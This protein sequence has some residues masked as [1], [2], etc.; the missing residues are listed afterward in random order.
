MSIVILSRSPG[1][2]IDLPSKRSAIIHNGTPDSTSLPPAIISL[3]GPE[4]QKQRDHRTHDH[5]DRKRYSEVLEIEHFIQDGHPD[6][7][8][9]DQ[10]QLRPYLPDNVFKRDIF[11]Q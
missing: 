11:F 8:Q 7:I 5:G 6:R 10:Y 4:S 1:K 2:T 9:A 3:I